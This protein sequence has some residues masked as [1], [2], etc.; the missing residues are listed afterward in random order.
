[1]DISVI[2]INYNTLT[3]TK[4]CI[5]SIYQHT[6]NV[7]FE[8]VLVDNNS[9]D[10][11]ADAL[12]K[13]YPHIKVISLKENI[14]FGRANNVGVKEA[15]GK[16]IFLLNSDTLLK[17]N[18]LNSFF[19]FAEKQKEELGMG[20]IGGILENTEGN[21]CESFDRFPNAK[22]EL[23]KLVANHKR[24]LEYVE[25][26]LADNKKSAYFQVDYVC[27]ADMFLERKLFEK[28][29]GFDPIFFMYYE[30]SDMQYR[31]N[32]L[33]K[34]NYILNNVHII[35][36][37]GGSEKKK[38]SLRKRTIVSKSC[39]LYMKKHNRM[40]SYNAFKCLFIF[41]E[42]FKLILKGKYIEYKE[43]IATIKSI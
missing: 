10:G 13:I 28:I 16:Y 2:I 5:A 18:A 27:G 20:V 21:Q 32:S 7:E 22:S 31:L 36:Y 33:G 15:R 26:K 34:R 37:G 38:L 4:E 3:M 8:I 23:L 43:Y 19:N 40:L 9:C 39:L 30:E 17:D 11:S 41:L 29:N 12:H 24:S 25:S 6:S 1:M 42:I 14:G 35:H